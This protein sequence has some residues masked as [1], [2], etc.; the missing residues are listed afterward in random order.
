MN[1]NGADYGKLAEW[2]AQMDQLNQQ[3]DEKMS[4]WEYLSEY[5]N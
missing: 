4:R 1:A 5:A 3:L 2:Q